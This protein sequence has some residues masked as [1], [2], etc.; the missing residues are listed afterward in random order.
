[1][2]MLRPRRGAPKSTPRPI[3]RSARSPMSDWWLNVNC[4]NSNTNSSPRRHLD[5][6]RPL[7]R[8]AAGTQSRTPLENHDREAV[9]RP[10]HRRAG[11]PRQRRDDRQHPAGLGVGDPAHPRRRPRPGR[12]GRRAAPGGGVP[13]VPR[14]RR[15]FHPGR[16]HRNTAAPPRRRRAHSGPA[17]GPNPIPGRLQNDTGRY[18]R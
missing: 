17:G 14:R 18:R 12:V 3:R 16:R 13:E 6:R 2:R 4:C 15:V 9:L 7:R 10:W 1:M 8:P 11:V 5:P